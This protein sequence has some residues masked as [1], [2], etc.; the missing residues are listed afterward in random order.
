MSISP[1]KVWIAGEVL[2]AAD[3]NAS[4]SHLTTNGQSIAFPRTAAADFDGQELILDADGDSSITMDTNNRFDLRIQGADV[5]VFDGTTASVVNG[6]TFLA[7]AAGVSPQIKAQGAST[8]LDV[9]VKPKGTGS[10]ILLGTTTVNG[11]TVVPSATTVSVDLQASGSDTNI[12]L[13]LTPKGTGVTHTA[14]GYAVDGTTDRTWRIFGSGTSLLVQENTGSAGTPTWTTRNTFLTGTGLSGLTTTRKARMLNTHD[15]FPDSSGNVSQLPYDFFATN[16][17]HKTLVWVFNDTGTK[18]SLYGTF[19]VPSDYSSAAVI[20]PIWSCTATSGS[21]VWDFDYRV[22]GG[23]DTTSLDQA[24]YQE[25]LTVTDVAPTAA[26][27]RLTPSMTAT[28]SNFTADAT[29]EFAIS[30]DGV[31][32]ADTLAVSALLFDLWF[33]YTSV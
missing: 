33:S 23:D 31:D 16:D 4:F 28:G 10:V 1:Y 3:L 14:S 11:L 5:F 19:K 26:H 7:S 27:R 12:N 15:L 2:S 21:V 18:L 32:A 20:Q 6:L 9:N 25:A 8:N 17:V 22:V 30:R 24:T 29:V 13:K